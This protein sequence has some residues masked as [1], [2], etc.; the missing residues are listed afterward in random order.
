MPKGVGRTPARLRFARHRNE[1]HRKRADRLQ[2]RRH[3]TENAQFLGG[4]AH[5][6]RHQPAHL[7]LLD[8]CRWH[9]GRRRRHHNAVIGGVL[10]PSVVAVAGPHLDVPIAQPQQ[11]GTRA[12]R[13]RC[14]D[15]DRVHGLHK[16]AEDRGLVA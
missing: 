14:N 13:K 3:T 11:S 9:V 1:H 8:Q 16:P 12:F 5:G 2:S 6:N 15:L 7:Q 10:G 4:R